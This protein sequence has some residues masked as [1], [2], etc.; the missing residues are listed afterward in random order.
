MYLIKKGFDVNSK[1][2]VNSTP[3][4]WA[5]YSGSGAA[6]SYLVSFGAEVNI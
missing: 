1:D 3:L 6:V 4:H 2:N 5:C